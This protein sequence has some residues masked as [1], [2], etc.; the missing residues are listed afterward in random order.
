MSSGRSSI[1]RTNRIGPRT[2][3]C[4]IPLLMIGEVD[5]FQ[6]TATTWYMWHMYAFCSWSVS[7]YHE[8]YESCHLVTFYFIKNSFSDISKK[9]ILSN[10]HWGGRT[11][12]IKLCKF[13]QSYKIYVTFNV[14]LKNHFN[15]RV[16]KY[17]ESMCCAFKWART[18][19]YM[20]QFTHY[21]Y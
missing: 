6:L 17:H 19:P 5:F 2:D 15:F 12:L 3:P 14:N 7:T 10:N 1:N 18:R 8:I 13:V 20:A 9:C 16:T 21:W 4:G 11:I